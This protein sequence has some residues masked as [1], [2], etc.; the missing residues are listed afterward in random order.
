MTGRASVGIGPHPPE[1]RPTFYR[2]TEAL[3]DEQAAEL[4]LINKKMGVS[5]VRGSS[6]HGMV[7]GCS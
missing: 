1:P 5:R 7:L 4:D 6:G 2:A 3:T